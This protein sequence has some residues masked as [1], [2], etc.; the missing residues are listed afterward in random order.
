MY[1]VLNKIYMP[2]IVW[3]LGASSITASFCL[4]HIC[5]AFAWLGSLCRAAKVFFSKR[6]DWTINDLLVVNLLKC[7]V[8]LGNGLNHRCRNTFVASKSLTP[9]LS[10]SRFLLSADP[11]IP[12]PRALQ[13][14]SSFSNVLLKLKHICSIIRRRNNIPSCLNR[15]HLWNDTYSTNEVEST[16]SCTQQRRSDW[17]TP[18]CLARPNTFNF[19][20]EFSPSL[21]SSDTY[22]V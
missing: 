8:R 20:L 16:F 17:P 13:K 19:T 15:Q 4:Q 7:Y 14:N 1:G 3:T 21:F 2:K 6:K 10:P 5:Q 18:F 22:L 9:T 11:S 12:P